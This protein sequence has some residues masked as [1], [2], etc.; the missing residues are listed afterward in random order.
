MLGLNNRGEAVGFDVDPQGGMHGVI[1]DVVSGVVA[2]LDDPKGIGTTTFNGLNDGGQI[3][4]FY[5][6]GGG[7]T[8]G[9]IATPTR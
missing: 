4:G 7:N 8:I 1:F 3:V 2:E 6:N 9:L 5:V